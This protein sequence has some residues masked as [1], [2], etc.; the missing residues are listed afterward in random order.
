MTER[1]ETAKTETVA[2]FLARGGKVT[3][4]P[5]GGEYEPMSFVGP[6]AKP[7]KPFEKEDL[8]DGN[9]PNLRWVGGVNE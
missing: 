5:N 8:R 2:E 6:C 9:S 3:R 7:Y 1:V 4:V